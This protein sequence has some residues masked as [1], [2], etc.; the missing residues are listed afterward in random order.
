MESIRY[1]S[2]KVTT[3]LLLCAGF[4]ARMGEMT[5]SVPKPLLPIAGRPLL[6][7][8]LDRLTGLA[9]LG[10]MHL[11][12]NRGSR[13][14]FERWAGER[15]P[16]GPELRLWHNGCARAEERPGAIAD[17]DFLWRRAGRP[18]KAVVAGGDNIFLFPLAPFWREF[19]RRRE[20]VVLAL[21]EPSLEERQRTG[22]LELDEDDRVLAL[23]EKP[24]RPPSSW[25]CPALYGLRCSG[26]LRLAEYLDGDRP[27]DDLG[28]F[29]AFLVEREPVVACRMRGRRLHVGSPESYWEAER[30]FADR[31]VST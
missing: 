18:E 29:I 22:V 20:N 16:G 31:G 15:A 1:G 4:G 8:L 6:D 9:E 10:E 11:V 23:H 14:R 5:R 12:T 25:I 2:A 17:L 7:H 3:V 21:R 19:H 28:R 13:Q 27:S 26:L 30:Y 24:E